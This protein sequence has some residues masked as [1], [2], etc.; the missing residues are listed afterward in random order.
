MPRGDRIVLVTDRDDI[1]F[2]SASQSGRQVVS[3]GV[4][5]DSQPVSQ[6][7]SQPVSQAD[8]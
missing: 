5:S 8:R 2:R 1:V 4:R 3:Q 6:S 7:V